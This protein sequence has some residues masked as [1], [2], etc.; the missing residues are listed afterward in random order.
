MFTTPHANTKWW[1]HTAVDDD[2][3]SQSGKGKVKAA[4]SFQQPIEGW[5]TVSDADIPIVCL[6]RRLVFMIVFYCY[7]LF[8][9]TR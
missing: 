1:P 7:C 4:W 8:K 3:I 9:Y 2:P 6:G 5:K